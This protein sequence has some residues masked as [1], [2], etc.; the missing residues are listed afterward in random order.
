MSPHKLRKTRKKRGSRTHGWGQVGQ[1]RKKSVKGGR[2]VG[3]HKH[4]W[5]YVT[6]YEPNYFGKK[7]FKSP[8]SLKGKINVINVGQLDELVYKLR[9]E[10]QLEKARGKPFLDLEKLGYQKLLGAGKISQGVI[11][12]VPFCSEAAAL[13]LKEAGGQILQEKQP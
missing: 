5:T 9:M 6:K 12:K 8:K 7:G 1:H 4:L 2:K 3:R 13:K 11:V 10:K